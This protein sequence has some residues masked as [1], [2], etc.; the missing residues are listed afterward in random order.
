MTTEDGIEALDA[1][2]ASGG[3]TASATYRRLQALG[4]GDGLPVAEPSSRL[5]RAML[6]ATGAA[7]EELLAVVPPLRGHLTARG[8]AVCAALAGCEPAHVA[9][10]V[11]ACAAL[12]APELN[13]LGFSTTTGSA[14]PLV[15]VNGPARHRLGFNAGPNCLGPG[16]RAN[17]TVGRCLSLVLRIVGGAR[18]GLADMATVGQPAKYT[19]CFAEN[20]E[21][22]PWEPLHAARGLGREDSAVTV[23]GVA[24]TVEA[25][26]AESAGAPDATLDAVAAVLAG[27][28]PVAAASGTGGGPV[29]GGQPLVLVSPEWAAQLAGAG[30]AKADLQRELFRRSIRTAGAPGGAR[31]VADDPDD[32]LV[33]VAGGVGTKQTVV[34]NW[35]GGSRA[36]TR[37]VLLA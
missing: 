26:A 22:S 21:A 24:G 15:V 12:A 10:L 25:F 4:L 1:I 11:A 30:L 19:C 17:A 34:P 13:A 3:G 9:V 6:E 23:V 35:S 16:N 27:S 8:L 31:R 37:R 2:A 14:A 7:P 5:V 28:A 18:E 29:G 33:V 36:V 32:V 20:E